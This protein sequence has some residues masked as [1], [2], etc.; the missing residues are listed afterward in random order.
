MRVCYN[1]ADKPV[2]TCFF[3]FRCPSCRRPMGGEG[4]VLPLFLEFEELEC[5][6]GEC[7]E[8]KA[9]YVQIKVKCA[10]EKAKLEQQKAK[11]QKDLDEVVM[12]LKRIT[13]TPAP[14]VEVPYGGRGDF[15]VQNQTRNCQTS[16]RGSYSKRL[17]TSGELLI[18]RNLLINCKCQVKVLQGKVREV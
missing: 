2:T 3:H 18:W 1:G 10:R 14:A 17:S 8:E 7:A 4:A 9:K 13:L 16:I 15:S 11:L 12:A 5:E 6:S